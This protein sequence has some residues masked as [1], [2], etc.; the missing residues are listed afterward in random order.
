MSAS[1]GEVLP[2]QQPQLRPHGHPV[3]SSVSTSVLLADLDQTHGCAVSVG[4]KGD[5]SKVR[6][7]T[8]LLPLRV[9]AEKVAL[10]FVVNIRETSEVYGTKTTTTT[11][12]NS[13]S[14]SRNSALPVLLSICRSA[15]LSKFFSF[16]FMSTVF[17]F[18]P[19]RTSL[20]SLFLSLL[21]LFFKS[22]SLPEVKI[23]LKKMQ[24][25][26]RIINVNE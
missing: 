23:S 11:T 22:G 18:R 15:F 7:R 14:C 13:S 16:F 5:G 10:T 2:E 3:R 26:S 25:S 9:T 1:V 6:P 17:A 4:I 12:A 19:T 8:R 21:F 24:K 20:L